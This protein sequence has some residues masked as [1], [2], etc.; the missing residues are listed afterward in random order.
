MSKGWFCEKLEMDTTVLIISPRSAHQG[1]STYCL[2][3]D[4]PGCQ[5]GVGPSQGEWP[6][7]KGESRMLRL[8]KGK[9]ESPLGFPEIFPAQH[10]LNSF[11]HPLVSSFFHSVHNTLSL[12]VTQ[13]QIWGLS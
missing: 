5:I 13:V 8:D 2:K 7:L 4:K 6:D 12:S 11:S 9:W 3:S 10:V 1:V